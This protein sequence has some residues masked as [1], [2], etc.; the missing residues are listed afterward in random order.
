M[1]AAAGAILAAVCAWVA[2]QVPAS[3]LVAEAGVAILV[4]FTQAF[5][6]AG[7]AAGSVIQ[8]FAV[9][10]AAGVRGRQ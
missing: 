6:V 1:G 2:I 3:I 4:D 10:V 7:V 5:E 9:G 8:A